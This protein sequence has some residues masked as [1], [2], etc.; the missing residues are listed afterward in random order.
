MPTSSATAS[1]TAETA[2]HI[3]RTI[4]APRDLVWQTFT[5]LDHLLRWWGPKGSALMSDSFDL[6]PGGRFHYRMR[7]PDGTIMWG[8]FSY[9]ELQEPDRIA[10]TSSFADEEGNVV[11]APFSDKWPLTVLNVWTFS[12]QDGHTRLEMVGRP[13]KATAEEQDQFRSMHDSMRLG[14]GGT[15]DQWDAYLK[16]MTN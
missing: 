7:L 1:T 16:G 3:T 12:E 11:R 5:E 8:L 4:D 14:F 9:H 10:F 2:F 15:F 13:H 6:R